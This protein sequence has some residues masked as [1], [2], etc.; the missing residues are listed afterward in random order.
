MREDGLMGED[1]KLDV[2]AAAQAGRATKGEDKLGRLCDEVDADTRSREGSPESQSEFEELARTVWRLRQADGCPWDRVQTHESI[3][4]NMIEEAYEAV[5]T[6]QAHDDAHMREELGDVLLQ[7]LLHA[8]IA[9][10]EGSFDIHDV[11]GDLNQKLI[12]RHPHVFGTPEGD[13]PRVSAEG[14]QEVPDIWDKVKREERE[15]K[16]EATGEEPG[17]LDSVP[18]SL[19]ALMQAQ[20]ISKRAAKMGFDWKTTDD[21]WDKV[22]EEVGEFEAEP[23][24]SERAFEEFGDVLFTLVNVARKEHIDAEAALA[25]ANRKFRSRWASM[26]RAAKA[27]GKPLDACSD[28]EFDQL[29]RQAKQEER[30]Q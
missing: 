13:V 12:R 2:S 20:K 9:A 18:I 5:D 17:L 6:F 10:D 26:E 3:A 25:F 30:G 14:T 19:P 16:G 27:S 7:V 23:S 29:W 21:V 11:C 1:A 8:Q 22:N 24:G 28:E 15:A 4:R